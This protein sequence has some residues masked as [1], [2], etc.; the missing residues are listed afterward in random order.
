VSELA[1]CGPAAAQSS[2]VE[3]VFVHAQ[4]T[5]IVPAAVLADAKSDVVRIYQAIGVDI[6]WTDA[7]DVTSAALIVKVVPETMA[8][9][10]AITSSAL[11]VALR[12]DERT[13]ARFAYVLYE[14][15]AR[16]AATHRLDAARILAVSIAHELGHLLLS[17]GGHS[18]TGLMRAAWDPIDFRNAAAGLLRFTREQGEQIREVARLRRYKN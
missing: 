13:G 7:A 2:T 4:V 16:V 14:R 5:A 15:I 6:L 17:Y 18:P 1:V 9:H 12:K 10:L 3:R 11:G 8:D